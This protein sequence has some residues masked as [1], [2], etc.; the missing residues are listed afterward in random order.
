MIPDVGLCICINDFKT[1]EDAIIY[2]ADGGAYHKVV[3]RVFVFRPFVGEVAVGT[4]VKSTEEGITVSL[5]FFDD[6]FIPSYLLPQP[7]EYDSRAKLWV[8]KYEGS[9][10]GGIFSMHEQIRFRIESISFT[11]V[12]TT[13]SGRQAT[14]HKTEPVHPLSSSLSSSS[15]SSS[16]SGGGE[17]MSDAPSPALRQ[18]STSIDLSKED[19]SLDPPYMQITASVNDH[20]LGLVCWNWE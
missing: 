16:S 4:I 18:R 9:E 2:P 1:V 12:E 5:D 13:A 10:E 17:G 11:Q 7:S 14:I 3:F 15:S 20:G 8:W 6:V 19:K